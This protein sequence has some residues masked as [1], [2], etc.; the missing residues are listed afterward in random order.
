MTELLDDELVI[1]IRMLRHS[2]CEIQQIISHVSLNYKDDQGKPLQLKKMTVSRIC[3]GST[4]P[5]FGGPRTTRARAAKLRKQ[6]KLY[7]AATC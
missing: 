2:G 7:Q 5:H 6:R 4:Y 1:M 3:D